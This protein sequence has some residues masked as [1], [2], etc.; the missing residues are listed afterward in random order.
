MRCP[1]LQNELNSTS[2]IVLIKPL[3]DDRAVAY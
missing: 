1:L 3:M 2:Y